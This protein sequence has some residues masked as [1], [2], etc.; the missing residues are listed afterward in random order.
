MHPFYSVQRRSYR[1][2]SELAPLL[3]H[4][5]RVGRI[6]RLRDFCGGSPTLPPRRVI[7]TPA[8]IRASMSL[9]LAIVAGFSRVARNTSVG[10]LGRLSRS[11]ETSTRLPVGGE[12]LGRET[13]NN[14]LALCFRG[15]SCVC[16]LNSFFL[17]FVCCWF[18]GRRSTGSLGPSRGRHYTMLPG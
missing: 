13:L 12:N 6:Q 10:V 5:A 4:H 15:F 9:R 3:G 18:V 17:P 1:S 14:D 16:L 7:T 2:L 11:G 8:A